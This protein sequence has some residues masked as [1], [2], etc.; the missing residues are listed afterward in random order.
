[1]KTVSAT[2]LYHLYE[3]CIE[4]GAD[5]SE[6]LA[7]IP[8]GL[9]KLKT[10]HMRFPTQCVFDIL[11]YSAKSLN[12]PD[13]GLRTGKS[14][15]P[16]A[17][18]DVGH[19]ILLCE[20]LRQVILTNRRYQALT[21][22]IGRSNLKIMEGKAWLFWE[23][24]NSDPQYFR[25]ITEAVMANH[26]QFG[27]WLSWVHNKK[28][29]A[30]YFRH[31]E[32]SYVEE[33]TKLFEC[34]VYFNQIND[35]MVFEASAIDLPLS[36]PNAKMFNDMCARLDIALGALN[37][38]DT[39]KDKLGQYIAGVLAEGT[40]TL[41]VAAKS[42]SLSGRS[43]RRKLQQENTCF[44]DV[45][46]KTRREICQRMIV[47]ET[48]SFAEISYLLGYSEQSAFNRAFKIWYGQSPKVYAQSMKTLNKA[49]DQLAF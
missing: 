44:R 41:E 39:Y 33:Y 21:Q 25:H 43:L 48:H 2:Y 36:H 23:C 49:F 32:P 19:A 10:K 4:Q 34:P 8:G 31:K 29:E 18:G 6:L 38:S 20:S 40:P 27:R 12:L 16:S 17:F 46:E 13:I 42:F 35:A 14:L 1:M 5:N 9:E 26:V 15:R 28:I 45:L 7:Y 47:D 3:A 30:I 11:S 37:S 24:G 22:Q